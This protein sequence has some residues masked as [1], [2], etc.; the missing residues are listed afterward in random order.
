MS[1]K[2]SIVLP[3]YNGEKYLRQSIDSILAQTYQNWELVI[4]DDAS[5]D[6]TPEIIKSYK[7]G[8]IKSIR[9]GKNM[10][11][12]VS[13]NDALKISTGEYLTYTSDDNIFR[14]HAL[15]MMAG[16]LNGSPEL[17]IIYTDFTYIDAEG[18]VL[19]LSRALDDNQQVYTNG[20]G[21]SFLYRRHVWEILKYD[22]RFDLVQDYDFWLRAMQKFK[23]MPL[24]EDLYLF[25]EHDGAQ[26]STKRTEAIKE[27]EDCQDSNFPTMNLK[28]KQIAGAYFIAAAKRRRNNEKRKSLHNL[29]KALKVS[30]I[31]YSNTNDI[32]Y[33][34]LCLFGRH[35]FN[36][37]VWVKSLKFEKYD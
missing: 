7:D 17:D 2:V 18:K 34:I 37:C 19:R 21:A 10:K 25:R 3:V 30:P 24:H 36:F 14:P 20:L 8:R 6:R 23:S 13:L 11:M 12:T 15:E 22:E 32:G 27:Y 33:I 5:N 31:I 1:K 9:H 35:F 28:E 4:C 16:I 26:T 29:I